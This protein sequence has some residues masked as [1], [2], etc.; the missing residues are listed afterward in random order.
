[1]AT[2]V[3]P[4]VIGSEMIRRV[5]F[6]TGLSED[7]AFGKLARLWE[8]SQKLKR[9]EASGEEIGF[10]MRAGSPEQG[11]K[12]V[13]AYADPMAAF[14]EPL[15]GDIYRIRGNGRHIE[16]AV[17]M[18]EAN[19]ERALRRWSKVKSAP[20]GNPPEMPPAENSDAAGIENTP[21]QDAAGSG[22][23]CLSQAKPSQAEPSQAKLNQ[24]SPPTPQIHPVTAELI[25]WCA[26]AWLE[27]QRK[28]GIR[29]PKILPVEQ[30]VIGRSIQKHTAEAVEL[31][32]FGAR[33]EEAFEGFDPKK[34]IDIT[35]ILMRNKEGAERLP[36][37]LKLG[38]INRE[39]LVKKEP[40]AKAEEQPGG[41]SPPPAD[42]KAA[43][44][45]FTG[46]AMPDAGPPKDVEKPSREDVQSQ[47]EKGLARGGT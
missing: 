20:S 39:R 33:F 35:R 40:A 38:Q 13:A 17:A 1:M 11:A 36:K 6:L 25:D 9:M 19:R 41:W 8:T 5:S 12:W 15:E 29:D 10:W 30:E 14:L 3:M 16:K 47:I 21:G 18:E 42:V 7:E 4:G 2:V 27:T 24:A 28:L 37:F 34:N 32:L 43:L 23:G 46:R 26:Q 44:S 22:N 45:K 31:A